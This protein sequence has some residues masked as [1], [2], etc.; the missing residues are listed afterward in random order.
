MYDAEPLSALPDGCLAVISDIRTDDNEKKRLAELGIIIDSKLKVVMHGSGGSPIAFEIHG[1]TLALRKEDC[2]KIFVQRLTHKRTVLLVGNPNVGK[3]T[4]F[5]AMTGLHQHTGNWC[6][7][8]VSGA[9]GCIHI[10][11][12]QIRCI[13]TPGTYAIDASSAEEAITARVLRE[14]PHDLVICVCDATCPV[15]GIA[16]ALELQAA[17]EHVILCMNLM[18][19]A[20]KKEIKTDLN[21]ISMHLHMPV[22][23]VAAKKKSTL[24]PLLDAVVND[25]SEASEPYTL[26][27]VAAIQKASE[28]CA[29]TIKY[30][31]RCKNHDRQIDKFVAGKF[32]KYPIMICLLLLIFWVT[33][34]GA[35]YP[36]ALLSDFFAAICTALRNLAG[37]LHCPQWLSGAIIDGILRGTGWVVSV[38]LPPMA[39]FFPMFTLLEDV[40]LLPRIAFNLDHCCAKCRAC[41]KQALTMTMG[42]GCNAVG[43]TECRIIQSKRERLIAILTNSLVPCNGRFP[44]L[45]AILSIFFAG[46]D[47]LSSLRSAGIMT[48]LILLCVAVTFAASMFLSR[49]FLRG[50]PSS[51]I[52]ELP[53]YRKPQIGHVILR[54]VLDRT[55]FVLGRAVMTAAPVSLLIWML[56][57]ICICGQSLL[58]WLAGFMEPPGALI[59]L[60]GVMLLAFLLGLPANEIVLPVALTAYLGCS[61]LTDYDSLDSLH[62]LLTSHGWTMRTAVCFLIFTLFHSPCA[63]TLLTVYKETRSKRWTF[64]AF[65][66]PTVIGITLCMIIVGITHLL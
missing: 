7:K 64:A 49:T 48:L 56:A 1:V 53:P 58:Q 29:D 5:N 13:D 45:L 47:M 59:G 8:T 40:G 46:D 42:F 60:D 10:Q 24:R 51:F 3:S 14:I 34:V 37:M 2:D 52:L 11:G 50:Q 28:I 19:E 21:K 44:A 41:G 9:E 61:T 31:T 43:V 16:L 63:T 55:I 35:N 12:E 25:Q 27:H 15:R 32:W 36:S 65:L 39:I 17:G 20:A 62:S 66:L 54:S 33:M 4:I 57:N 30:S 22:F 38:M 6:G 23:G 26:D 18:D